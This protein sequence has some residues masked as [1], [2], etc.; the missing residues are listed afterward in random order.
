MG[1]TALLESQV[2]GHKLFRKGKVRDVYDLGDKLL[3]IATDRLSAFDH[4]LPT[5]IPGKGVMLT[6]ASVKWFE[7][8]KSI[9][10]N[11]LITA[12]Y[13]QVGVPLGPEYEG[14]V[15]LCKK[16]KRVDVECVVRG[17]LSG[18]AWKEYKRDGKVCGE[19]LPPKL[20]ES[21]KL[22]KPI[23]TPATK[24]DEGHDENISKKQ[25]Q[26]IVGFGTAQ[27]V[28]NY[29]LKLYAFAEKY[30]AGRGVIL[31]DTKF[32]FGYDGDTLILI[33]EILTPDSSRLWPADKYQPGGAPPSFDKQ[34]VRDHLEKSGWN[35]RAPAP[36]IPPEVAEGTAQ[37][38]SEFLRIISQ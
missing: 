18:S 11:H 34:F 23:F 33:D 15:M 19:V 17:Y 4:V 37:R 21:Q 7:L 6:Q 12:D 16:A 32:E 36:A 14:R 28:E 29:S 1:V 27:E 8:T 5:A 13:K 3:L 30:L 31:A 26:K 10:P 25:L 9:I 35:K 38:Y 24:A 20:I 22:P 2:P